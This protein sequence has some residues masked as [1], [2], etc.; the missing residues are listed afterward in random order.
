LFHQL[1]M[2]EVLYWTKQALL[3]GYDFDNI[4][5]VVSPA[6]GVVTSDKP[7]T[8]RM[9]PAEPLSRPIFTPITCNFSSNIPFPMVL[10]DLMRR[11]FPETNR[12]R[13]SLNP[14]EWDE[15]IQNF[16]EDSKVG[17]WSMKVPKLVFR[18]AMRQTAY[19]RDKVEAGEKCNQTGRAKL[20][21]IVKENPSVMDVGTAGTCGKLYFRSSTLTADQMQA[22]KY[23]LYLE[24]NSFWADRLP[25]MLFS[26]SAVFLQQTPCFQ[27]FEPLLKDYVHHVPV[28][29]FLNNLVSQIKWATSNDD[30]AR[31]IAEDSTQFAREHLT[32]P[33][34][35]H[36]VGLLLEQ[37]AKLITSRRFSV[38]KA[39]YKYYPLIDPH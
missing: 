8:Y 5:F 7:H 17:K 15:Q 27:Y 12:Y 18:G 11:A 1:R 34:T 13:R 10:S 35:I 38:F 9:K 39:A 4:E 28:D 33:A 6:D 19:V 20:M 32:V 30:K 25:A 16:V 26:S 24:G 14:D 21:E 37:Y 3:H 2:R 23:Q 31:K 29:Y 22:F 36:Y